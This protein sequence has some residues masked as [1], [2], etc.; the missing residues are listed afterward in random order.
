MPP[1]SRGASSL[2]G[3][4][5]RQAR[6]GPWPV[7]RLRWARLPAVHEIRNAPHEP[8]QPGREEPA[9]HAEPRAREEPRDLGFGSVVASESRLRLV[10][11]DGSFNVQR[12]GLGLRA[13]LSLYYSLLTLSW[14]RFLGLLALLYLGANA[15]FAAAY[16]LCGPAALSGRPAVAGAGRFLDSFFF[17]VQTLS[18]IGYG[19]MLPVGLAANLLVTFESLAGLLFFAVAT[20]LI[21]AR[22]ARPLAD[23][24]FS[25]RAVVAPYRGGAGFMLRIANRRRNE[26][27][28]V[29]AQVI[30][31]RMEMR[32][33]QPTRRFYD[34]PL[35]RNQ[36]TIFPLSWTIVHPIGEDS[37][38]AGMTAA[39]LAAV[40][41]EFLVL[42]T[43][44][45]E[46]YFQR[47]YSRS[48]YKAGEVVWNARF[49]DILNHPRGG[50]P[51]TV[52]VRHLHDVEELGPPAGS[53]TVEP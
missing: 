40:D 46:T 30:F 48:S 8:F 15:V 36:V 24:V 7:R 37:P 10:N 14:P 28:E 26:L 5:R 41:G 21:F 6:R 2:A 9:G 49:A 4:A 20:G 16:F 13:S 19:K 34:L 31:S 12:R 23:I 11:R 52:D 39:D 44:I 35:E 45:D 47:V 50:E 51:I 18:T 27:V 53:T 43:G 33:G 38:L 17:S 25:E 32:D 1:S 22:F 42:L 29:S 3:P